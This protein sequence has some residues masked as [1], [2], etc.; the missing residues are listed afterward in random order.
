MVRA[1]KKKTPVEI[2]AKNGCLHWVEVKE[3]FFASSIHG[4]THASISFQPERRTL[5]KEQNS[6]VEYSRSEM[7]TQPDETKWDRFD[8]LTDADIDTAAASDADDPKTDAAFWKDATVVMPENVIAI[9]LD[10]LEWFK[11]HAPDYETQI[12][13]VLREYVE[14]NA[15][16]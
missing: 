10:L 15:N 7:D 6:Y 1:W 11:T 2:M 16:N 3:E 9:D 4:A 8:A 13:T 14:A 5:M 12:N